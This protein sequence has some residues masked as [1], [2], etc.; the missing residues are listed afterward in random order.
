LKAGPSRKT[1]APRA[2]RCP[3][4]GR[5]RSGFSRQDGG[6]G[7]LRPSKG[8]RLLRDQRPGQT[9]HP[10]P[11]RPAQRPPPTPPR[12]ATAGPVPGAVSVHG[13]TPH[14]RSYRRARRVVRQGQRRHL[15]PTFLAA[16]GSGG[17][18]HPC[19]NPAPDESRQ[20]S[21]A[22]GSHPAAPETSHDRPA[23]RSPRL[24][25]LPARPCAPRRQTF[26]GPLQPATRAGPSCQ[27]LLKCHGP[28]LKKGWAPRPPTGA[29]NQQ[30]LNRPSL[31]ASPA[32]TCPGPKADGQA[33]H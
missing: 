4:G 27:P 25:L 18:Y 2:L 33:A 19:S 21:T 17:R 15:A 12:R 23:G 16:T 11:H 22:D 26:R 6:P 7:E 8:G 31:P 13:P 1:A 32:V 20:P 29:R 9:D 28:G 5:P 24:C 14:P 30:D 10:P 3:D